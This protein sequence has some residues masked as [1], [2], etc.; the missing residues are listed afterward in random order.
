MSGKLGYRV[1]V[2]DEGNDFHFQKTKLFCLLIEIIIGK[3]VE[4]TLSRSENDIFAV[5]DPGVL[6]S[7]SPA[8][9][10]P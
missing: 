8:S 4:L 1:V 7:P 5:I 9:K 2:Y 10:I 3:Y 6:K